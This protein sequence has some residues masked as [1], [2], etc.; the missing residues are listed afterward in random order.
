MQIPRYNIF[1]TEKYDDFYI[2]FMI[3]YKQIVLRWYIICLREK[4]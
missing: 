2:I 4:T 1:L 3:K